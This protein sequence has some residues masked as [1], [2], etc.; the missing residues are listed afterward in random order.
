MPR[1]MSALLVLSLLAA[2]CGGPKA[3]GDPFKRPARPAEL[4]KLDPLV[5][6]W[7]GT[8]EMVEPSPE[9]MK[10]MFGADT[11]TSFEGTME[12][13]WTMD[14]RVLVSKGGHDMGKSERMNMTEYW[15]WDQ[16][17]GKF[18]NSYVSDW[19]DHGESWV[20]VSDDGR[21]FTIRGSGVNMEGKKCKLEGTMTLTD[22]NNTIE[23]TWT[24]KC[25]LFQ[26]MTLKGT[27]RKQAGSAQLSDADGAD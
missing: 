13:S 5:G 17:A 23:W 16:H 8:A 4:A 20:T 21:T 14:D 24:E 18:Y 2:G 1:K 27:S 11:P 6:K 7:S 25:G 15:T 26:K 9:K 22:N 12:T 3:E 19:G 10:E